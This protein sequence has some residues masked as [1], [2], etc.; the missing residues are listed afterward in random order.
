MSAIINIIPSDSS[1]RDYYCSMKFRMMKVDVEKKITYNC[2]PAKG[3][4]VDFDWLEKNPGQLFNTE[5]NVTERRMMLNNERNPSCEQNCW[6]AEDI[7]AVSPRISR[8]GTIKTHFEPVTYPENIDLTIGSDCN[9]TCSYCLKEYSSAW[10]QDLLINGSYNSVIVDDDRY[11]LNIK[12]KV[13]SNLNQNTKHNS[14]H[15][16]LLYKELSLISDKLTGIVI[17]GGEPFLNN[18]LLNIIEGIGPIPDI[19]IFT[20]LGVEHKR[21]ISVLDKLKDYNNVRL[22]VSAEGLGKFLEFNR[23]GIKYDAFLKK[24]ELMEQYKIKFSFHSTLSNLSLFDFINFYNKFS[25]TIE[26]FEM[27]A[28]PTFMAAH[29]MDNDSKNLIIEQLT[30]SNFHGK[31]QIIQSLDAVPTTLQI[32]NLR[33]FLIEFTKRRPD[34]N[35]DIFPK[36]FMEW[37]NNVV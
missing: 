23:Y 35:T 19:K 8:N 26:S 32:Q 2:D 18:S 13:I 29:V 33:N 16:Q 28:Q 36:S 22:M 12:D 1:N 27:V 9:L 7:G 14:K 10:R 37:M 31:Q 25:S 21:F 15:A 34:I 20:G 11:T 17:T 3:H 30:N 5:V 24:I 6:P 4:V